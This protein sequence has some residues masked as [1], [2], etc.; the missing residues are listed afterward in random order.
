MGTTPVPV[1]PGGGGGPPAGPRVRLA[2][3]FLAGRSPQTFRAYRQDLEDFRAF[4]GAGDRDGA[5][6]LL[7]GRSH[8]EGNGLALAYNKADLVGRGLAAPVNR[9]LAALRSLLK[10]ARTLGLVP[11]TLEVANMGDEPYRDSRGPGRDGVLR[12]EVVRAE[13]VRPDLED[14]DLERGALAVLGKGPTGQV[15]L[16]VPGP[17]KAT[18]AGRVR[19][20]GGRPGALFTNFDRGGRGERQFI[21]S[22][23]WAE[24]SGA[25]FHPVA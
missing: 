17:T 19:L 1:D 5:A 20:R 23:R 3:T 11:W 14:L 13:V 9:R 12:A 2:E 22:A 4:V 7:V 16:T 6:G 18:L 15:L 25:R 10:L 21:T 24:G 8:G